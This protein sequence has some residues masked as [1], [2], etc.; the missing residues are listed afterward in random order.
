MGGALTIN[1][2]RSCRIKA[3]VRI[4]QCLLYEG[5]ATATGW[6]SVAVPSSCVGHPA[7]L[8]LQGV[9]C[10]CASAGFV[11]KSFKEIAEESADLLGQSIA[12]KCFKPAAYMF[13]GARYD[14]TTDGP[15]HQTGWATSQGMALVSVAGSVRSGRRT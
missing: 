2:P 11:G 4:V 5:R 8:L 3:V 10:C 6:F 7:V 14:S 13:D 1:K 9:Q 15:L 12:C